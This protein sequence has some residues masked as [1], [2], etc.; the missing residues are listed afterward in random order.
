M[1]RLPGLDL[2]S[3]SLIVSGL[4][5]VYDERH[6]ISDPGTP[7]GRSWG[8]YAARADRY[9]THWAL[10]EGS[11]YKALHRWSEGLKRAGGLYEAIRSIYNPAYRIIEF[12]TEHIV[13]GLLDPEAGDGITK[14]SAIP[15]RITD[16]RAV[17]M[18]DAFR[19]ALAQV[20]RDSNW[21]AQ[22]E[23]W[24]CY[25]AALGDTALM[26]L[27]D[28]ARQKV[29]LRPIYPGTIR[30]IDRDLYGNVK[31]YRIVEMRPDPEYADPHPD[32]EPPE[33][34]YIEVCTRVGRDGVRFQ[35]FLDSEDNPYDWRDYPYDDS[36]R[37][38]P[39]WTE[40][41]GFVPL[42]FTQHRDKGKGYG[43]SEVHQTAG[44]IHELNDLV[45]KVIDQVRKLVDCVVFY[46]GVNSI[47]DLKFAYPEP[48]PGDPH[49][50]RDR[51][52]YITCGAADARPHFLVAPLDIAAAA[53]EARA[54]LEEI[55]RDHDELQ[56][57]MATASGDA[58]G[59]ALRV[60]RQKVEQRV[61]ARRAGYDD[62]LTRAQSMS[63][64]I[65]AMKRYPGFE[66]F[67]AGSFARGE[68][69]H[70]IGDRPVFAVDV[71]DE[72][73]LKQARANVY[74]TLV[75]AGF[76]PALAM[77]QA[78]YAPDV[79][80]LARRAWTQTPPIIQTSSGGGNSR[81]PAVNLAH[82]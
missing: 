21:Q 80:D 12:W 45:S 2:S 46:S 81:L 16:P 32:R 13:G 34:A 20:W 76:P 9:R 10:Y 39:D 27:D 38:G 71:A 75:K 73:E 48:T 4:D 69:A 56:A 74:A 35:T 1:S 68:L 26:V 57:D 53:A 22:K 62:A 65:G 8:T 58:S 7:E 43:W 50:R 47:E 77:E 66:A 37:I 40:N 25:G 59:R 5:G 41:Y 60:A 64:S 70:A 31:G 28:P 63:I 82:M 33:V 24:C 19:T 14:P 44:K 3:R 51:A 42:V 67:D 52:P 72:L 6:R 61:M 15:I 18:A 30:H 23:V 11:I 17:P 54:L 55:E 29:T 36:P 78:G 79:V 49:P